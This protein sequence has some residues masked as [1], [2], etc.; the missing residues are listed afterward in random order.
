MPITEGA[1]PMR[2]A[3]LSPQERAVTYLARRKRP[4]LQPQRPQGVE[5]LVWDALVLEQRPLQVK[6][7]VHLT[8]LTRTQVCKAV[9]RM[10]K[11]GALDGYRV[12]GYPSGFRM[13]YH[14][15]AA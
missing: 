12:P 6:D 11:R 14:L 7:I 2:D 13:A 10:K 9:G 5:G 4:E 1:A 15:A 8:D 3:T